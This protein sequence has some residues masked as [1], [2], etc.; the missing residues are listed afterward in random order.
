MAIKYC[1]DG[2]SNT[3]PYDTWVKAAT[4]ISTALGAA[5][6]GTDVV[7]L[8]QDHTE[9]S[10]SNINL[11]GGSVEVPKEVVSVERT[12]S[13]YAKATAAQ[14]TTTSVGR[15]QAIDSIRL[16]GVFMA[17]NSEVRMAPTN[18]L[19][20]VNTKDC[21]FKLL[22]N[23]APV[24]RHT[25]GGTWV[26]NDDTLDY[27][28]DSTAKTEGA[29][30]SSS[31]TNNCTVT[32]MTFL[33]MT[34]R[35]RVFRHESSSPHTPFT[36]RGS[37]LSWADYVD[38]SLSNVNTYDLYGCIMKV[39]VALHLNPTV[40]ADKSRITMLGC[41]DTAGNNADRVA[42][43]AGIN[44]QIDSDTVVFRTG[45]AV[46]NG[47]NYS[48]AIVTTSALPNK[49]T[50]MRSFQFVV[51]PTVLG[52]QTLFAHFLHDSLTNLQDDEIWMEADYFGSATD[53]LSTRISDAF[54]ESDPLA[55]AAD[56]A[57]SSELWTE[58][59]TNPNKQQCSVAVTINK[60]API[61]VTVYMNKASYT[62][63][64]CPKIEIV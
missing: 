61:L 54:D 8:A 32:N 24:F 9:S 40:A 26:S 11:I 4:T 48:L 59:M 2:G 55:V 56:Q 52:A 21:T 46:V 63:Y 42:Q 49:V 25:G 19:H 28:G 27:G 41:D 17:S 13:T 22:A 31:D 57:A 50:P 45:G 47:A 15:T 60:I 37:D 34:Y 33:N 39:G 16:R 38:G 10:T 64:L 18:G 53:T 30:N 44:G 23:S 7:H 51:K 6:A 62:A 43:L 58:T 29:F 20:T 5:T 3:S 35:D 1:W 36:L 12:G 14:F